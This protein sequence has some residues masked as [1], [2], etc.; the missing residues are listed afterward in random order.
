MK[1]IKRSLYVIIPIL[2]LFLLQSQLYRLHYFFREDSEISRV[3]YKTDSLNERLIT[4]VDT[5]GQKLVA[6]T[7]DDGPDPLYTPAILEI[8]KN[9]QL[10][11]TFFVVGENAQAYPELLIRMIEAGHEVENHTY[12]HPDLSRASHLKIEAEIERNDQ[13]I[14]KIT[15]TK[16]QF[17]RPPKKL[18]RRETIA[19]AEAKGYKTVLWS[20][21]VENSRAATPLKMAKRVIK[22][23][24]PGMIILA[25]DGRLNRN[26]TVAALPLI[27]KEYQKLG[28]RFVTLE[29][30]LNH[31]A[32]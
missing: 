1:S 10:Q 28:Y 8:L 20:I 6:L 30:L 17:F 9:Y 2:L 29:E 16:A 13:V 11:A 7:F 3:I 18:F 5:N 26:K 12:T 22:S 19:I 15:G 4:R 24:K 21:C 27:I 31:K 14:Y 25:H 23:A 32:E